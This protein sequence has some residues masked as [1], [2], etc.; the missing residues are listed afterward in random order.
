[1]Y[2][3]RFTARG[4]QLLGLPSLLAGCPRLLKQIPGLATR[5]EDCQ[6]VFQVIQCILPLVQGPQRRCAAREG[7]ETGVRTPLETLL[8]D[9]CI[10]DHFVA[11]ADRI[12]PSEDLELG[13][14][15]VGPQRLT[16]SAVL[17]A[18]VVVLDGPNIIPLTHAL[19]ASLPA[20]LSCLC[21]VGLLLLPL[22]EVGF[23]CD[24]LRVILGDDGV[25]FLLGVRVRL[26]VLPGLVVDVATP[27]Q[28]G[29]G[30]L[31]SIPLVLPP[32]MLRPYLLEVLKLSHE[33]VPSLLL[34][35]QLV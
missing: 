5:R 28:E 29:L 33:L 27:S 21:F 3:W 23:H 6:R 18:L 9:L 15:L 35:H 1:M 14:C 32:L 20:A 34:R 31:P 16:V 13:Q 10:L 4:L 19:V 26:P 22:L 17:Q 30:L 12:V 8:K 24:E 25:T 11:R 2:P 7:F